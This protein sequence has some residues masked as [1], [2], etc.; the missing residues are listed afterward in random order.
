MRTTRR[1]S[2]ALVFLVIAGLL[3]A[4]AAA[5]YPLSGYEHTGIRRLWAYDAIERDELAGRKLPAGALMPLESVR[6]RLL[7]DPEF[8]IDDDTPRDAELQA[9]VERLLAGREGDTS[10]ALLDMTDPQ[11]LRYAALDETATYLPGSVGKLLVAVGFMDALARAYPHPDRR[12]EVLRETW[13]TADGFAEPDSHTV[14]VVDIAEGALTNR[15][16]RPGDRFTL[17]E[18]LDHMLSPSSNAAG[19]TVWKQA[20]LLRRFGS[21]FPPTAEQ[22]RAYLHETE[23]SRLTDDSL[24]VIEDQLASLGLRSDQ[25]RQGTLYTRGATAVVPGVSSHASP[26]ELLRLMVRLEQGRAVDEFSSLELK[27]LLYYTKNRYRY[28]VS[29]ALNDAA[30]YFKSGSYYRCRDEEG[31]QCRQYAGNV[32]NF[33]NSVT[34]VENPAMPEPGQTQRVYISVLMSNV[35]RKNS[36]EDHR[37]LATDIDRLIAEINGQ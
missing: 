11:N 5:T 1:L 7:A 16:I 24:A 36:A 9:G 33:M 29:G 23:K 4:D 34:V 28:A 27:R 15:A 31:F 18:W 30:V 3:A 19:A 10:I 35:L 20:M 22:E 14:P 17:F 13:I 12:L 25:L 21:S 6:L 26:R 37:D 2:L 8:D 32:Q